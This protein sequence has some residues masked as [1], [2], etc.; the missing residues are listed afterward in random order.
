M[1]YTHAENVCITL[2]LHSAYKWNNA[3]QGKWA[4]SYYLYT[5]I[6]L[7]CFTP[8]HG[9]RSNHSVVLRCKRNKEDNQDH[10][11]ENDT[12]ALLEHLRRPTVSENARRRESIVDE[13]N[14]HSGINKTTY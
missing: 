7:L 8:V 2:D 3:L 10:N 12:Q 4:C 14:F 1:N 5:S 13:R 11:Q 6:D 9:H